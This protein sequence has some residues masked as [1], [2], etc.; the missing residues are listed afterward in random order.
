MFIH[1]FVCSS[2]RLFVHSIV[3]SFTPLSMHSFTHFFICSSV[4]LFARSFVYF[5]LLVRLSFIGSEKQYFK[6]VLLAGY[7]FFAVQ[8][9]GEC[10]S[11]E[12]AG[13]TYDMYGP[14]E[15]C[16]GLVGKHWTN[17]VYK[18]GGGYMNG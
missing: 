6:V 5:F 7:K 13:V 2:I 15:D 1:L 18:L 12:N 16:T 10:F 9:Y 3:Y 11:S 8:F 17:F 14:S 4:H